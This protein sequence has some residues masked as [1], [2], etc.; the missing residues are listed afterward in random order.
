MKE[1]PDYRESHLHKGSIYDKC[2]AGEAISIYAEN[3]QMALVRDFINSKFSGRIPKY[4]DFAC[5]TGRIINVFAPMADDSV[6]IDV[7]ES[8]IAE[9]RIKCPDAKFIV[10]D[11][12]RELVEID[13]VNLVTAFRFFGNAQD[14]LRHG[15]LLAINDLLVPGG[16]LILNNHRNPWT[17]RQL[18]Y[19]LGGGRDEF[20]DLTYFKM[21]HILREAGFRIVR[22]WGIGWWIALTRLTTPKVLQSRTAGVLESLSSLP[23][24]RPFC[25]EILV[26]ARKNP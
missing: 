25:P 11:V 15:A 4:L 23:P 24:V 13:R 22:C 8:M 9:A 19:R 5:G 2:I 10:T 6:G 21:C 17:L 12:T 20:A 3:I 26:I 1:R 16:Y 18:T 7:S 14:E